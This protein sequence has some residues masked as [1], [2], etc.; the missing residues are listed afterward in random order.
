MGLAESSR[1]PHF[2]PDSMKSIRAVTNSEPGGNQ[3]FKR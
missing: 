2:S 1:R 3:F